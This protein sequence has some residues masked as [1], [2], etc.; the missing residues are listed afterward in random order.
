MAV[1]TGVR[2]A[3][4]QAFSIG[5]LPSI[6]QWAAQHDLVFL[7]TDTGHNP[8]N[9]TAKLS[10]DGPTNH[11]WGVF[12]KPDRLSTVL[13]FKN[14]EHRGDWLGYPECCR[15]HY[16]NTWGQGQVDST[17]EQLQNTP[18]NQL[19]PAHTMLRWMGI[20][21]VSHMPC[22]WSCNPSQHIAAVNYDLGIKMGYGD[23]MRLMQDVLRWPVNY[24]RVFGIAQIETPALRLSTRTDWTPEMQRWKSAYGHYEKPTEELWTDNGYSNPDDMRTA[25]KLLAAT[26]VNELPQNARVMDLGCGNALLLRRL[27]QLRPDIK[28]GGVEYRKDVIGRIPPMIGKW[29]Q[30]DL[31]TV[32]WLDWNPTVILVS[33]ERL[34]EM[35]DTVREKFVQDLDGVP[36]VLI[37]NYSDSKIPLPEMVQA[38]GIK[39]FKLLTKTPTVTVGKQCR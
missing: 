31:G 15:K 6:T 36:V 9:Y 4:W 11:V 29:Y 21:L 2:H 35:S 3:A 30:G 12:V 39:H 38:A 26:A 22:S 24:S 37:Y 5:E 28:I 8:G 10:T 16:A 25:H 23:E 13:P 27:K 7:P 1:A 18:S 32:N 19:T 14:D 33:G 34:R 17:W 20:R